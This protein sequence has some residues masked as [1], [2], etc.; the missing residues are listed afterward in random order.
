[1]RKKLFYYALTLIIMSIVSCG[2]KKEL[3]NI[4][5]ISVENQGY[6]KLKVLDYKN[7]SKLD[8]ENASKNAIKAVL[9]SGYS[10][11]TCQ[12][13]KPLLK[14]TADIE[15]FKKIENKFFSENGIWKTFVRNSLDTSNIKTDKKE[16]KDF[17][18]MINKDGLRKYLEEQKIIKPLN[19][20]F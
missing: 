1:M 20:G 16:N 11:A 14:E 19:T 5:C 12:T 8:V 3:Y 6:I 13:Q 2:A 10:S 15:K 18:I 9:Y 17:I 7:T 4:E